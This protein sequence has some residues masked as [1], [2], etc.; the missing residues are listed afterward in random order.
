MSFW[1]DFIAWL[2]GLFTGQPPTP[3]EPVG[4]VP[5]PVAPKVE[6]IVFDPRLPG[7]GNQLLSQA[8]GWGDA[9]SLAAAYINDLRSASHGYL[10][11]QIVQRTDVDG[12]PV[13][14]DGFSYTPEDYWQ[15]WQSGSGFH[16]PDATDYQRII[17]DYN[18]AA[19]I[20]SGAVDEVWLF[21]MPY[22][23]FYESIMVGPGA[24]FCNAPPLPLAIV[25][26][27]FIIMGFNYQRGVGEMLESFG[28]RAES[29]L[30]HVFRN[31]PAAVNL[32]ERF[33]RYEKTHPDQ[34]ECGNVHFA[35]NSQS[36]YDWGNTTPVLSRCRNWDSFPNLA[37]API[38]VDH[39]EW[40]GGD[41]RLH[42]LW[43]LGK[44]PH[45]TG[46]MDGIAC[47]WWKYVVDPNQ[48]S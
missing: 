4:G 28:H 47:N 37:G 17:S 25:S 48:I 9:G 43:W 24:V 30:R 12:F 35:P 39:N 21:G 3:P 16:Q 44:F 23:G 38:L 41:M 45:I 29:I 26:R 18:L 34:A 5:A 13:K 46:A 11:Y 8:L 19:K 42:H 27:R 40:G 20:N 10:D 14:I 2:R 33:I 32:W 7:Q 6:L 36:D 15:A 1:D 22:A 31:A